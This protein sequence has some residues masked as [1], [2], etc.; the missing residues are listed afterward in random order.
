MTL[1]HGGLFSGVGGFSMGFDRAGITT[2]WECEIDANCRKLLAAKNPTAQLH[3]DVSTFDPAN[4]DCP[5]IISFGS[6]CQ[7]LSVAGQRAGMAG[8]RSGLF[9]EGARIIRDFAR[10]GLQFA[11]WENVP[12]AF[13]SHGGRDFAGVLREMAQCGA[14]DVAWCVLDAQWQG[15]A[16]RRERLFLVA[17]FRG[18]RAAEVLSLAESMC[19]DSPPSRGARKDVAPCFSAR[20]KG[21]GGLRT[22]FDC[23]GGLIPLVS[24]S[25]R[26]EGFDASEG[27]TGRG[28]P[29]V[30]ELAFALTTRNERNEPTTETLIP[31][32]PI[33]F[34]HQAGGSLFFT[35]NQCGDVLTGNVAACIGTNSNASGR[36]TAKVMTSSMA[37][38]R[39]TPT[40]CER[41]MG[42][43]DGHTKGFSD[44]T[45]YK[46][47]GN[48]V[49]ANCSEY[50]GRRIVTVLQNSHP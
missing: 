3:D 29:L 24:H 16:Q 15:V 45:R 42:W 20:T 50:I 14:L 44:S 28:T 1:T 8:G 21:G 2:I 23:D 33:A 22:D 19:W 37:V 30:P 35:Q 34:N 36:N 27:G 47:C 7:D 31:S 32:G 18:E 10:R 11:I 46:M 49:V 38:R 12:G 39:L 25:L 5:T 48:G 40:E 9:Y 26:A 6:P 13:S 4:Y 41:L 17:D 43:E